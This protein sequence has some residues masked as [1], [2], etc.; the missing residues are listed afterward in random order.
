MVNYAANNFLKEKDNNYRFKNTYTNKDFS[1]KYL[2]TLDSIVINN[3]EYKNKLKRKI[4]KN[5]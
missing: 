5:F 2:S 3:P 4:L 1:P